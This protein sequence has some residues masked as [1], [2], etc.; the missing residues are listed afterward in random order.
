[1]TSVMFLGMSFCLP[2]AYWEEHKQQKQAREALSSGNGGVTDPLLYGDSLV[3]TVD[4]DKQCS[5][6]HAACHYVKL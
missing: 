3:G 4:V 2:W 6:L 5:R 1:M